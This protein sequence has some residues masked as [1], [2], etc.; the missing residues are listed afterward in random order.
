MQTTDWL[1]FAVSFAIVLALLGALLYV[2]KR[3]QSGS[4]LGLPQRRIRVLESAS[5]APRQKLVLVRVKDQELLLGVTAQQINTLASF[6]ASTDEA[7]AGGE[8]ADAPGNNHLAPLAHK[9]AELLKSVKDKPAGQPN[10]TSAAR[11]NEDKA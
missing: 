8:A 11:P 2:M 6:A 4:L 1:S 5:I 3:L 9:L 7:S 10:A